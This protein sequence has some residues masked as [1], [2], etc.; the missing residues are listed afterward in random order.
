MAQ[1]PEAFR[2]Q[3]EQA[4]FLFKMGLPFNLD[5]WDGYPAGRERLYAAFAEAGVQPIVLAGDSHAF[6][7]NELKDASGVRRAVEFGTSSVSSPS[8]GDAIG[9]FPLGAALMQANDEVVFCD[10]SAKGFI[11]LTLTADRAE[12]VLMQVSTILAKP[13]ETSRLKR[14][15]LSRDGRLADEV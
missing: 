12:A 3:F 14:F 9:G 11:L 5:A 7:V 4:L 6:W 8:I 13:F 2:E 15:S 1:T 10:Q